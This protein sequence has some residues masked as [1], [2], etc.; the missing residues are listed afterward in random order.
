[1]MVSRVERPKTL[2]GIALT[3]IREAIVEGQFAFGEQLS[4]ASLAAGLGISKTPVREA[5][6]RLQAEGLVDVQPQVGTFV[7]RLDATDVAEV[8]RFRE[9]IETA[10]LAEAMRHHADELI[11]R[12]EANI[13]EIAVAHRA[14]DLRR[15]PLLDQEF[16][17]TIIACC[18]NTYLQA[19]YE[20]IAHKIRALRNRLPEENERVG[21]CLATHSE[22]VTTMRTASVLKSQQLL[23]AHI[24]DTLDSYLAASRSPRNRSE[25]ARIGTA[26]D[27]E[28]LPG[29][30][31]RLRRA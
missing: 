28:V 19:S 10:A 6:L 18:G 20:L 7:F 27:Q 17:E 26:V 15:L 8:C 9:I 2:T 21:H 31:G 12:L 23:A 29:D 3:Q 11:G 16:H 4:E 14:H 30:E 1:M 25:G 13:A 5:L 24:R 22:L